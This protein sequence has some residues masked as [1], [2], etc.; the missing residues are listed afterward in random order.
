MIKP[1]IDTRLL[2]LGAMSAL[3]YEM[4]LKIGIAISPS[5]FRSAPIAA[6]TSVLSFCA[7]LII[8][9]FL[10][11]LAR[12]T[13]ARTRLRLMLY[14]LAAS[15]VLAAAFRMWAATVPSDFRH[16]RIVQHVTSVVQAALILLCAIGYRWQIPPEFGPLARA[17]NLL[18]GLFSA[19]FVM[20]VLSLTAYAQFLATGIAAEPGPQFGRL[21]FALFM[22]THGAL[23][24]FLYRYLQSKRAGR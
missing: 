18:I 23:L 22:F 24:L 8:I 5:L 9:L 2:T 19:S 13:D 15:M 17:A 12:E 21:V 7:G 11:A 14:L 3:S 6:L 10:W 20:S 4:L 1:R 16:V